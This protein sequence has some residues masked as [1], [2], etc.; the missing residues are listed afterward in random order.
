MD[1]FERD[2]ICFIINIYHLVNLVSDVY[3]IRF[4]LG[5]VN[6]ILIKHY[7]EKFMLIYFKFVYKV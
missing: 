1:S 7:P 2:S 4:Y 6:D 5:S 3:L